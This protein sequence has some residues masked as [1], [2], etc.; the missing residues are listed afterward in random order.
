MLFLFF[1]GGGTLKWESYVERWGATRWNDLGRKPKYMGRKDV[2][3]ET[4]FRY[5]GEE[6]RR[7]TN[8][9]NVRENSTAFIAVMPPPPPPRRALLL[10]LLCLFILLFFGFA[11]ALGQHPAEWCFFCILLFVLFGASPCSPVIEEETTAFECV[12]IGLCGRA[13]SW[14]MRFLAF[15]CYII[16]A[17]FAEKYVRGIV[18]TVRFLFKLDVSSFSRLALA[19]A[20]ALPQREGGLRRQPFG[21]RE[22]RTRSRSSR[23]YGGSF[24]AEP[25]ES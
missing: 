17:I 21:S 6:F 20:L 7:K 3:V 1:F 23:G 4:V 2:C 9:C 13:G 19:L 22:A 10:R 18:C 8:A 5:T 12:A 16:H 14:T 11:V 25:R 24:N 15:C